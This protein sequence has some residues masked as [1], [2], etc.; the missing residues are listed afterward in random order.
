VNQPPASILVIG[1]HPIIRDG[2]VAVLSA[3]LAETNI[4]S[5][6]SFPEAL[7]RIASTP[8]DLVI[9]DFRVHSDTVLPFLK[10]TRK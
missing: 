8:I 1:P 9:T 4:A 6:G 10:K 3:A 5:S 2:I 7:T